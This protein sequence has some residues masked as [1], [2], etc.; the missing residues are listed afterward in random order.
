[1]ATYLADQSIPP[2]IHHE[3]FVRNGKAPDGRYM[4]SVVR[5]TNHIAAFRKKCFYTYGRD[6]NSLVAGISAGRTF[7]VGYNWNGYNTSR[8]EFQVGLMRVVA[9][10]YTENCRVKIVVTRISDTSTQTIYFYDLMFAAGHSV[11]TPEKITWMK[12]GVNVNANEAYSIEIVEENYA[13][14]VAVCA[15]EVGGNPV[16]DT[17][18]GIVKQTIGGT[19]APILD[20]DQQDIIEAQTNLWKR[21]GSVLAWWSLDTD[22]Y[23]MAAT[24]YTNLID[25]ST[26]TT[27]GAA[28]P[29]ITLDLRYHAVKSQTTVPVRLAALAQRTSGTGSTADNRVRF[30]NGSDLIELTGI[31]NTKQWYTV[32]G[33]LPVGAAADKYDFQVRTSGDTIK[34][35]GVTV[36]SYE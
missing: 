33:T 10:S 32:D 27:V 21:N 18:T 31:G 29:G 20:A 9:A 8:L 3:G 7:G 2:R 30:S 34:F 35:Y 17:D 25:R 19:G 11:D 28:T 36:L 26:T 13:R 14:C 5:G 4:Q 16:D 24:T 1:M 15:F 22:P 6:L 23:Q 12:K